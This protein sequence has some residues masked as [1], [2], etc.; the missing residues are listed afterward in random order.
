MLLFLL[1][2]ACLTILQAVWSEPPARGTYR[3]PPKPRVWKV[4]WG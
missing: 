1:I 3:D 4:E 2:L